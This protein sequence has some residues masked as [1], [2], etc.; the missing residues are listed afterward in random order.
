MPTIVATSG[1]AN[2]NSY[3]T[4]V[5][6]EAYFAT[7]LPLAG[8]ENADDKSVLLIMG[9]RVLDAIARPL[10]RF[11]PAQGGGTA[12]YITRRTWTGAP[13][14]TTQKLA[15][16]RTGMYDANGN[17]I[18]SNVIPQDLKDAESELAGQLGTSDRTL[19]NDVIVQ[20][21]TS[22]KAG[23]VALTF[24]D[25]IEARVSPDAVWDL[26]PASWFAAEVITPA[27]SAEFD[28][29]SW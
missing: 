10:R 29:V 18:A 25:M 24:K 1:A 28:V 6:A 2:A 17:A 9:T 21:I 13:A 27:L 5:E 11:V 8:W 16:P 12:Y 26:M 20:G 7:R 14:T 23:S 4:L 3:E 15:W 22:I 19:E